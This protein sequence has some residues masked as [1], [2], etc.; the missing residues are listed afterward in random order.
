MCIYQRSHGKKDNRLYCCSLSSYRVISQ[1][2]CVLWKYSLAYSRLFTVAINAIYFFQMQRLSSY[3]IYYKLCWNYFSIYIL[4]GMFSLCS[5]NKSFKKKYGAFFL[6]Y[7]WKKFGSV[8]FSKRQNNS[9][10]ILK[11][12]KTFSVSYLSSLKWLFSRVNSCS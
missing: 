2:I 8:G 7:F 11:I 4:L 10:F 1:R 12:L 9:F 6:I 5:N 3:K